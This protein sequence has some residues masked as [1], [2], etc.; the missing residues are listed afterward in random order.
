[1]EVD[2]M[3]SLSSLLKRKLIIEINELKYTKVFYLGFHSF[4][5]KPHNIDNL[6]LNLSLN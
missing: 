4:H 6:P 3:M 1:M 2:Q 5:R